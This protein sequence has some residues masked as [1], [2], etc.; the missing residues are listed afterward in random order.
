[1][2]DG[3]LDALR[4]DPALA[5]RTA[6]DL[7]LLGRHV[8]LLDVRPGEVVSPADAPPHWAYYCS[9]G[10][11]HVLVRGRP[12]PQAE[13]PVLFLPDELVGTALVAAAPSRVVV[14]PARVLDV[15]RTLAPGLQ[16]VPVHRSPLRVRQEVR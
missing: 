16:R 6:A 15:V 13:A 9:T 14:I 8:D 7:L 10:L 11:L 2:T 3:K 4:R 12:A 5:P 1:M